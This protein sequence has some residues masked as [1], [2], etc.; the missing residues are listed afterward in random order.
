MSDDYDT[1]T[2]KQ[3]YTYTEKQSYKSMTSTPKQSQYI[4]SASIKFI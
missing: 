3:S 2:E 4:F 1:Y